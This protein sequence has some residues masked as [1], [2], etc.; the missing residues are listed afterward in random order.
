MGKMK[1]IIIFEENSDGRDWS[2]LNGTCVDTGI[3]FDNELYGRC[4]NGDIVDSDGSPI[5]CK[6]DSLYIALD[7]A[8]P[9][10]GDFLTP[11]E[12]EEQENNKCEFCGKDDDRRL[13]GKK[14]K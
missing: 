11:Q 5:E 2:R 3:E 4:R 6:S 8:L 13:V 9:A 14:V 1:L 12:R 10:Y 7:D